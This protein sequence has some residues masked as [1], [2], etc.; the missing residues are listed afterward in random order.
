MSLL[1]VRSQLTHPGNHAH[2]AP[3]RRMPSNDGSFGFLISARS[4]IKPTALQPQ[5]PANTATPQPMKTVWRS[6]CYYDPDPSRRQLRRV[7]T[8]LVVPG[9]ASVSCHPRGGGNPGMPR[10]SWTPA[11]AGGTA[12]NAT[13]HLGS[14]T[15]HQGLRTEARSPWGVALYFRTPRRCFR[16]YG[17]KSLRISAFD[18]AP[19]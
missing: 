3:A 7:S 4:P 10:L 12:K 15:K 9:K 11:C 13:V 1:V 18:R 6:R 5:V 17:L 16:V 2:D 14:G 19:W 8:M